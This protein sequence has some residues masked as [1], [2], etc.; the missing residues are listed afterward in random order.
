MSTVA[1]LWQGTLGQQQWSCS[2]FFSSEISI[3]QQLSITTSNHTWRMRK[4]RENN[5]HATN[6]YYQ[7][8]PST[9][10]NRAGSGS[11]HQEEGWR[12]QRRC[13]SLDL[14]CMT[15]RCLRDGGGRW[16]QN[17]LHP[18]GSHQLLHHNGDWFRFQ[19]LLDGGGSAGRGIWC[20]KRGPAWSDP[21]THLLM[22]RATAFAETNKWVSKSKS[23]III[24]NW[25]SEHDLKHVIS[26][27]FQK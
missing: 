13:W 25:P 8:Y 18:H 11:R 23:K 17:T 24:Y 19:C 1:H 15:H 22:H 27:S 6:R 5:G 4:R 16:R 10:S 21:E 14:S 26:L 2:T 20:P 3:R 12:P 7:V 9:P